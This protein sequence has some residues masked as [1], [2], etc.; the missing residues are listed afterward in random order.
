MA[1]EKQGKQGGSGSK[2]DVHYVSRGFYELHPRSRTIS[3]LRNPGEPRSLSTRNRSSHS[4]ILARPRLA[5][6]PV[7]A[8]I[9]KA[10][11][12]RDLY[13]KMR[14][15]RLHE[16]GPT[17]SRIRCRSGR[18]TGIALLVDR[19]IWASMQ[20]IATRSRS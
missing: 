15:W 5:A 14:R 6:E 11:V 20:K 7:A 4:L 10:D 19:E 18:I 9:L 2:D 16:H 3:T 8:A 1:V 13:A 12:D 17:L